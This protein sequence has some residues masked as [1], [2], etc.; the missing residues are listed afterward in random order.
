VAPAAVISAGVCASFVGAE[1]V[2]D[3]DVA[4]PQARTED[5]THIS[6]E[7][8]RISGPFDGHAG[9]AP[10]EPDGADHG[11]S[12]P[13]AVRCLGQQAPAAGRAAPQAGHVCLRRRLV[14]EDQLGRVEPALAA[15]PAP[16]RPDNVRAVLFGCPESLF[17]KVRPMSART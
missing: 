8:R 14:E 12:A 6:L 4:G 9:G 13:V 10:I 3:H 2:H 1:V 5:L 15:A 17:L 7:D 11:R 16:A